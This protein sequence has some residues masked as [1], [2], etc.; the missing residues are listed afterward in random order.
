MELLTSNV[1]IEREV[2]SS[3]LLSNSGLS[4]A[5]SLKVTINYNYNK[6]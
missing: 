1:V 3:S 2:T 5:L 6:K 4:K